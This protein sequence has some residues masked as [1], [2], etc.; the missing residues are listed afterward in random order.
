MSTRILIIIFIIF[1]FVSCSP[2]VLDAPD[3]VKWVK[4]NKAK[5]SATKTIDDFVFSVE[6]QPTEF[7]VLSQ[8]PNASE[9]TFNKEVK[10][11][12]G[13]LYFVFKVG[14][15]SGV[16]SPIKFGVTSSNEYQERIT[17]FSFNVQK[18]LKLMINSVTYNCVL[19]HF[20]RTYDM[21]P[22]VT[23]MLGFEKPENYSQ[24]LLQDDIQFIYN[25]KVWGLGTVK[26]LIKKNSINRIPIL[27]IPSYASEN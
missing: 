25:D 20:E 5:I 4:E 3:Y 15:K 7:L 16:E 18:E 11:M 1:S 14:L 12:N 9:E 17:Y 13:L 24:V 22:Y 8:M 10:E 19:H 26:L 6:Y 23:C 21:V 2:K 27:N